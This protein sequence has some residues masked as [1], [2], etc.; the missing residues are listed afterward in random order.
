LSYPLDSGP[1]EIKGL[2]TALSSAASTNDLLLI[3]DQLAPLSRAN[4]YAHLAASRP[5]DSAILY[6]IVVSHGAIDSTEIYEA[7][8]VVRTTAGWATPSLL[9]VDQGLRQIF[10]VHASATLGRYENVEDAAEPL[11]GCTRAILASDERFPIEVLTRFLTLYRGSIE[12]KRAR[13]SALIVNAAE[14][15]RQRPEEDRLAAVLSKAL[16]FWG[17][18]CG[19][20]ILLNAHQGR[21]DDE[22]FRRPPGDV[23]RLV[24]DLILRQ[25]YTVARQIAET[26]R[27]LPDLA[28]K[29]FETQLSRIAHL[30]PGGPFKGLQD[31]AGQLDADPSLLVEAL[32]QSGFGS[33]AGEP[34]GRL[35][36][37]FAKAAHSSDET[38]SAE[39]WS[40]LRDL[41][42]RL[43]RSEHH[44]AASA[45]IRGLIQQG[46]AFAAPPEILVMLPYDLM[47][48]E[49]QKH[50]PPI[51][52][53]LRP[54]P[55]LEAAVQTPPKPP[56]LAVQPAQQPAPAG[57]PEPAPRRGKPAG[58]RRSLLKGL[59]LAG[60]ALAG[61]G[62]YFGFGEVPA[63][64]WQQVSRPPLLQGAI[65]PEEE[66]MPPVG[67][68]QRYS[69][70]YVRYCHFQQ[71]RLKVVKELA[72]GAE[73]VRAYNL[74][75]VDY[76]SR[77]SDFLYQPQ[78][79]V[80]AVAEVTANRSRIEADAK[81]IVSTWPGHASEGR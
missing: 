41:A 80:T 17:L 81:Q 65:A 8:K 23:S 74:L 56:R 30:A 66:A 15:L 79:L 38:D 64:R 21:E 75:V 55:S 32:E 72:Q 34:A 35:W 36:N 42:M 40:L 52:G 71:E 50:A 27:G 20:L 45:L 78:D 70:P 5:A 11:L 9:S 58:K 49:G 10:D 77:C 46:Q 25:H 51:E 59:R 76:N 7:L 48:I 1:Y 19:P 18:L 62:L 67:T 63:L 43:S 13:A 33:H 69:L 12:T 29:P 73:N 39:P 22:D 57:K 31:L 3:A 47:L 16:Q 44:A 28:G 53:V 37:A 54:S 68:G 24:D 6:A 2:Y 26:G 60:G 4:F 61:A 14:G